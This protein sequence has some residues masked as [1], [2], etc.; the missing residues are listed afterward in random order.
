MQKG[1]PTFSFSVT[2]K[3][4][5]SKARSGTITTPHGQIHTPAF[6]ACAT[7]ATLK[8]LTPE[9]IEKIGTQLLFVNTYHM[10][11]SPGVDII[12]KAGGIHNISKIQKPLITDSGGFQVFSLG[13]KRKVKQQVDSSISPTLVKV[14]D[15]GVKFRSHTDG[16][17]YFFTPEFSVA[18]QQKI[19]A[20]FVVS[21]D[22]CLAVGA[23]EKQTEKSLVRTHNWADRSLAQLGNSAT[24]QMYGVVQGGMYKNLRKQSAEY[25]AKLPF[26]G[27]AIGGVSVGETKKEMRDAVSTVIDVLG[28][29]ARPRHLLGVGQFDDIFDLVMQGIDT[30]DCVLPT[31]LARLGRLYYT[32]TGTHFSAREIV[33]IEIINNMYKND[34]SPIDHTCGCYTCTTF[35]R[36]YVHHLF[37]ERE[38]LGYTLATIHNLFFMERVFKQI[39]N[40]IQ[41]G[42]L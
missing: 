1:Q 19:G 42:K 27:I 4:T 6:V 36:A 39:K 9:M 5:K 38:L 2:E 20:D 33:E 28:Q 37:K 7:K 22:E 26:W 32:K 14:T 18:A 34:L 31:R 3:S 13:D 23:S 25:I 11:L 21:F 24:Q 12:E 8:S 41:E 16:T 30:F 40:D 15:D 35:T 17:E 29:D 10:V